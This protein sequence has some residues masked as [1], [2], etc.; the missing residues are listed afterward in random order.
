MVVSECDVDKL[1]T[2]I[3]FSKG[4]ILVYHLSTDEVD[5]DVIVCN[6]DD[7]ATIFGF[8]DASAV[9]M[10]KKELPCVAHFPVLYG[11]YTCCVS[12][13]ACVDSGL[14]PFLPVSISFFPPLLSVVSVTVTSVTDAKIKPS[15]HNLEL[16][17]TTVTLRQ[18]HMFSLL[19]I[20]VD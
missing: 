15:T 8:L 1:A 10:V 14:S 2:V 11:L 13:V 9:I 3:V 6:C 20:Q 7:F 12:V 5:T 4:E 17:I 18:P 16:T 19:I